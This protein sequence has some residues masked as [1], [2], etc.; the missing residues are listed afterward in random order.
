MK[1]KLRHVYSFNNG[2]TNY[3][4]YHDLNKKFFYGRNC[5]NNGTPIEDFGDYVLT[6]ELVSEEKAF[7][8]FCSLI[9]E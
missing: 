8:I 3:H 7:E 9:Q 5:L 4:G 6:K 2:N 1:T